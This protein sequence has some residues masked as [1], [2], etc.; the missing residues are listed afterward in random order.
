MQNG[1]VIRRNRKKHLDI[2]QFRWGK[3]HRMESEYINGRKLDLSIRF[4]ISKLPVKQ[5]AFSCQI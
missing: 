5:Q 1:S 2:W 3:R 4:Q